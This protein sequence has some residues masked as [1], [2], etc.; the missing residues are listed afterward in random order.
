MSLHLGSALS[1]AACSCA[2][3]TLLVPPPADPRICACQIAGQLV[4]A[5]VLLHA[6]AHVLVCFTNTRLEALQPACRQ[7]CP[8]PWLTCP[9]CTLALPCS[10]PVWE[11]CPNRAF[12]VPAAT[13]VTCAWDEPGA[14][15]CEPA[16]EDGS[17]DIQDVPA[18]AF[19]CGQLPG[20]LLAVHAQMRLCCACMA[21]VC[22]CAGVTCVVG[23]CAS[24]HL[25]HG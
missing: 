12:S 24:K 10:A 8:S 5:C 17:S 21:S 3:C 14:T 6:S 11:N 19:R 2:A 15:T 16:L 20:C 1:P 23:T 9:T 7:L 4:H 13:V 22:G 18:P 25:Q